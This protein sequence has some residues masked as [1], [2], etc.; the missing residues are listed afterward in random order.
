MSVIYHT[1]SLYLLTKSWITEP[2]PV[3]PNTKISK[4]SRRSEIQVF[5]DIFTIRKT[6]WQQQCNHWCGNSRQ[7]FFIVKHFC[8]SIYPESFSEHEM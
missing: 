3:I 1:T 5:S 2:S 6:V 8:F 4:L 7:A